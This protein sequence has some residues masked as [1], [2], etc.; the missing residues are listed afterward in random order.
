MS[1][2][3]INF[4]CALLLLG[5]QVNVNINYAQDSLALPLTVVDADSNV[6]QMVTIGTQVW[7]TENL[8]TT[9]YRDSLM[10]PLVTTIENWIIQSTPA[11]CWY[12]NDIFNKDRYGAL[13]NWSAVNTN[14]LCPTGWHV[15]SD[16]EWS[17]LIRFLGGEVKAGALVKEAGTEH[18]VEPNEGATNKSGF[19]AIPNGDRS[20]NGSFN[21]LRFYATLW[22]STENGSFNA[23]YRLIYSSSNVVYRNDEIKRSGFAVRCVRDN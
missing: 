4:F 11:Y 23:W 17:T 16:L 21:G 7:M 8:K 2:K 12:R 22:S 10:I 18:W 9:R 6:Y 3:G 20:S 14:K 15:P 19:T 1:K 13:Y 5:S